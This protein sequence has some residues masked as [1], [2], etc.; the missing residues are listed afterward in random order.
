M[1]QIHVTEWT[2]WENDS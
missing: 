1:G 2:K